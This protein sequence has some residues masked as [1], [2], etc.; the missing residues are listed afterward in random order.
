[1]A[2]QGGRGSANRGYHVRLHATVVTLELQQLRQVGEFSEDRRFVTNDR[3]QQLNT[4][5]M[6]RTLFAETA[7]NPMGQ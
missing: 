7:G 3:P 5:T 2:R 4:G 6:T 1:M